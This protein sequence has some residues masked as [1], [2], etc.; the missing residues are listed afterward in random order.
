MRIICDHCGRPCSG[1]VKRTPENLNFHPECLAELV[2]G[3]EHESTSVSWQ[4]PEV[5]ASTWVEG[6]R[7]N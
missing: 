5:S 6:E 2:K 7:R 1:A 3:I 4:S